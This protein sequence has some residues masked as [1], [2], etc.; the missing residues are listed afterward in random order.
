MNDKLFNEKIAVLNHDAGCSVFYSGGCTCDL[1]AR[2]AKVIQ[3]T[4]SPLRYHHDA[5]V[6]RLQVVDESAP[7]PD[8]S[9]TYFA[10]TGADKGV[11]A[12]LDFHRVPSQTDAICIDYM[13]TR[14]DQ[15]GKGHATALVDKLYGM[16]TDAAWIEWGDSLPANSDL[17]TTKQIVRPLRVENERLRAA[18]HDVMGACGPACCSDCDAYYVAKKALDNKKENQ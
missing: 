16:F 10:E 7:P 2:R 3:E 15:R 6:Y 11:V 14:D 13:A 1:Q 9:A 5:H 17:A 12:F 4:T 18:L 8:P